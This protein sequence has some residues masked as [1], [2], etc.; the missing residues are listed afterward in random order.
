MSTVGWTP[1]T[2]ANPENCTTAAK[3]NAM[4]ETRLTERRMVF[5]GEEKSSIRCT[6]QL[7]GFILQRAISGLEVIIVPKKSRSETSKLAPRIPPAGIR[8]QTCR[9]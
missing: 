5:M 1:G 8:E 3:A 4:A 7:A 9:G 2:G 6:A